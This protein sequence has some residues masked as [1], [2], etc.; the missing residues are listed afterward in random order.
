VLR[1]LLSVRPRAVPLGLAVI[2]LLVALSAA[3]PVAPIRDAATLGRVTDASLRVPMTYLLLAPVSNILDTVT[4]M[5]ARQHIVL[6]VTIVLIY[7][8][9]WWAIGRS[10]L[11]KSLPARRALREVARIGVGVVALLAV[12]IAA[13]VLRRPMA[14][15]EPSSDVLAVDF[16]AHTRFSHDGRPDWSPEDVRAWHRDAGFDVAFITDHRTFEGARDAWPNNSASAGEGTVLLPA[17]EVV[18]KGEHVNVL[19]ADRMYR[20][21]LDDALRD[22][23]DKALSMISVV[24]GAEP[25]LIETLPGNLARVG[26]AAGPGTPG[27]RAIEVVDGSPRG[28][29]Q[30]RLERRRIVHLADST[31]IALVAGSD[32]HGWGRAA[33]GWTLMFIPQWR[34]LTPDARSKAI[35][36]VLRS[37]GRGAT[38]V[39][40]RYV[41]NT[42]SGIALPFSAPLV[43]WG[44]LR[45]LSNDERVVWLAWCLILYLGWRFMLARR[46]RASLA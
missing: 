46:T 45:S 31:N 21:L 12:Y 24:P 39:V 23:D 3:V 29:E 20:G 14:R 34:T 38:R 22:V 44:M 2:A 33:A 9:W 37:G 15:L 36:V 30:T 17:I 6:V 28:L 32:N 43:A 26:V 16:H 41:A 13:A 25:V 11:R 7:A 8:V 5:S 10:G 18:W 1:K 40:A 42:E 35:G 4:L 27:V 19:E